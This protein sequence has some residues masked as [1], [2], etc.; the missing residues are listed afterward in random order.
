MRGKK[1]SAKT[2]LHF[3]KRAEARLPRVRV[4]ALAGEVPGAALIARRH[5]PARKSKLRRAEG[6][7]E[8]YESYH[9]ILPC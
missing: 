7:L 4:S 9:T 6:V 8:L 2:I 1:A 5:Q 3:L